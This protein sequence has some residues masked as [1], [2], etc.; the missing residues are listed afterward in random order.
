MEANVDRFILHSD[1]IKQGRTKP[2][3]MVDFPGHMKLRA[4]LDEFLIQAGGIIFLVDAADFMPNVRSV[5]EYLYDILSKALIVKYKI[6]V[7][8]VAN[9]MD[10]V[11]AHS[12]DFIRKQLEKEIDKLCV[13][14]TGIS[15][16]DM[17]SEVLIRKEGEP[18]KFTHCLNKVTVTEASVTTAQLADVYQFIREQIGS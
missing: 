4:K 16:A 3:R 12:I 17:T 6:P 18:F 13:T 8:I 10:K 9:K 2:V 5:A 1:S 14:R 11:T 7:L 15:D